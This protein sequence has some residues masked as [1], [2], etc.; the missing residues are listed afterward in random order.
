MLTFSG[1]RTPVHSLWPGPVAGPSI[2]CLCRG[3]RPTGF[4]PGTPFPGGGGGDY[5]AAPAASSCE[6]NRLC[7]RIRRRRGSRAPFCR[8]SHCPVQGSQG[9]T[10]VHSG[11]VR[12]NLD[13]MAGVTPALQGPPAVDQGRPRTPEWCVLVHRPYT[14]LPYK[15]A[16]LS[17]ADL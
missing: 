10:T 9:A 3:R 17:Y 13:A 16:R 15:P 5:Q 11:V 1:L 4:L 14:V 8:R 6:L 12:G 2:L 7:C